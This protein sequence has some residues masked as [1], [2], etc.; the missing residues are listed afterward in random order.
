VLRDLRLAQRSLART[1]GL[2]A[3]AVATMGLGIGLSTAVFSFADRVLLR[4][5]PF[6]DADRLAV[7][8]QR[9]T[10]AGT[11]VVELS[12]A[13]F[14]EWR[15]ALRE[16]SGLA[17]MTAT[18]FRLNLTGR[19]EPAQVDGA[20]VSAGFFDVVGL[21][22]A[23]GRLFV[24]GDA[25]P[26]AAPVVVLSE[27]YWRR[28]LGADESAIGAT[29]I[30]DGEPATVVGVAPG[31]LTLPKGADV[32]TL[33]DGLGAGLPDLRV[34]KFVARLR[35]GADLEHLRAELEAVSAGLARQRPD[36]NGG[37]RGV[38]VPLV[39]AVWGDARP[40]LR[41]VSAAVGLVLLAACANVAALLLARGAQRVRERAVRQALGASRARL[42]GEALIESLIVAAAGAAVG[43]VCARAG[44]DVLV[45]LA[46][47][48]VPRLAA[49]TIDP[50]AL[51]FALAAGL[52]AALAAGLGPGLAALAAPAADALREG[53]RGAAGGPRTRLLRRAVVVA[54]VAVALG[55]LCGAAVVG[56][57]FARTAAL[58]PGFRPD[59]V[60][61][62]RLNLGARYPSHADRAAFLNPF[63]ERVRSLPGVTGAAVVLLRPLRDPIGWDYAFTVE[64][65]DAEE[66][67]R[68]PTSNHESISPDY[69][70]TMGIP[71]REGRDF[72]AR[73]TADSLPVVVVSEGLARRY[74]AAG[75][76]VGRRLKFGPPHSKQPWRTIVGVVGD[77]RYRSWGAVWPDAYVPLPQ[78]SFG[79]LDLVV[80]SDRDPSELVPGLRAALA[81][82]DPELALADVTTMERVVAQ[83]VAGPRF[84]A[85]VLLGFAAAALALCAVSLHG[86]LA[87][88]VRSRSREIG[89]RVALGAA[90][91]DVHRLVVGEGARLLAGG[92]ALGL[93][94]AL[95]GA[96]LL[97][98]VLEGANALDP[99]ALALAV[100]TL[101]VVALFATALPAHDATRVDPATALREE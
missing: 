58:D 18:N 50:R 48:E 38:A 16:A 41:L 34:L 66:Q 87:W 33:A 3:A 26:G 69:F 53:T 12:W 32:F 89:V 99:L 77:V 42:L 97:A 79:R 54:Q 29:L 76:A 13:E 30:L 60:V 98:A 85:T 91:R 100:S 44:L 63:L 10:R 62:A 37:L 55:L 92:V 36:R 19:G 35:D 20:A 6:R 11:P 88:S 67:R 68:N 59:G 21:V 25:A 75:S 64:G 82:G 27:G 80:R 28:A 70:R 71:L 22:P 93:V 94:L 2:F 83:A 81:A 43:V 52:L 1:P 49:A 57:A 15:T 14:V 23:R 96:R 5:L 8:W 95:A 39:D 9:D 7:L 17:A 84:T 47:P 40:A 45:A 46:P 4:P 101:A 51:G 56:R 72:D 74:F 31:D 78:W 61:T 24:A 65:Q 90:A 73:D 86:L